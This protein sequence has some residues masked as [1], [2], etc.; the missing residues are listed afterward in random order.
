MMKDARTPTRARSAQTQALL[1]TRFVKLDLGCGDNKQGADW[2][3][4]DYRPL[5]GV[6]IV[7]DLELFPY[8]LPDQSV[9]LVMASHVLE[10]IDKRGGDA[11]IAPLIRLLLKK[12]LLSPKEVQATIGEID[13]GPRLIRLMDEVWRLL[14]P[15]GQFMIGLPYAGSTGF[16]QDPTHC[17]GINEVTWAYF[18]PLEPTTQGILYRIYRPSPWRIV[19]NY[20]NPVGMGEILLEKRKEDKSYHA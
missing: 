15:G 5:P 9:D 13:P 11:R 20:W 14:K 3:G 4:M 17:S 8:P 19:H 12:K 2:I 10:H 18:D 6:D 16:W 7:H 1:A